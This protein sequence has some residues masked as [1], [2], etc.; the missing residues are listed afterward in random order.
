MWSVGTRQRSQHTPILILPWAGTR[1]D[2]S[3]CWRVLCARRGSGSDSGAET[4]RA[5]PTS[6]VAVGRRTSPRWTDKVSLSGPTD[7]PVL[8]S[9]FLYSPP[10]HCLCSPCFCL[11]SL[12][13]C[14]SL[15]PVF[16][17]FPSSTPCETPGPKVVHVV[18]TESERDRLSLKLMCVNLTY[19]VNH[20]TQDLSHNLNLCL[21]SGRRKSRRRVFPPLK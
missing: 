9:F 6:V 21:I 7:T 10:S 17:L 11:R 5:T 20:V 4:L 19:T 12:L 13:F 3:T 14:L 15:I 2:S 18:G 16:W 1:P 8:S